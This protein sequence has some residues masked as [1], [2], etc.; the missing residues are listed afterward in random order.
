VDCVA[1]GSRPQAVAASH[2]VQSAGSWGMPEL[3]R[4]RYSE[5]PD[6]WHVFYGDVHVGT[7]ARR[8]GCPADVDQWEWSCGFYPG[9]HPS[10]HLHDTA[11]SFDQARADFAPAWRHF[12]ARRTEADYQEWR[13]A[14]D[15]TARKYAMWAAGE[16][17]P[18]QKP[19]TTMRCP[20]G[21][22]FDSHDPPGSYAHRG[23]IYA[24][25]AADGIRR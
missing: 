1:H 2:S 23:H 24:A 4:R 7:I 12:S 19:S 5:R 15:W 13:D 25:Q 20:C 8:T 3:A 10:E 16:L 9:S 11:A 18:S 6:C 22:T 17:L 14:R 21:E